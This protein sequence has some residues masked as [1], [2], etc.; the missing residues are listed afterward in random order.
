MWASKQS[1]VYEDKIWYIFALVRHHCP[2][3]KNS[4][5]KKTS[6]PPPTAFNPN[7]EKLDRVS[8]RPVHSHS[9]QPGIKISMSKHVCG[10][11][12]FSPSH[13]AIDVSQLPR[14]L[15]LMFAST[16]TRLTVSALALEHAHN[17]KSQETFKKNLLLLYFL[18]ILKWLNLLM[19]KTKWLNLLIK[20]SLTW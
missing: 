11:T 10:G 4:K 14:A 19:L 20:F 6:M 16:N 17:K 15:F 8:S 2:T 7:F 12:E 18:I 13:V 9:C 1:L 5:Y 3:F